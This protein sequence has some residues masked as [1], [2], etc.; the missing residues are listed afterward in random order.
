MRKE[1]ELSQ[2]DLDQLLNAS[3]AVPAVWLS[4]G[5][6]MFGTPQENANREWK[7]VGKKYGFIWDTAQP[8][9]GKGQRFITAEEIN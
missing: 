3:K 9:V 8:V 2:D 4:G 6:P 1:F 5:Q 7:R